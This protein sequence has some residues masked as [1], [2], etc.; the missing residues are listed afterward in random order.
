MKLF[1]FAPAV[2]RIYRPSLVWHLALVY[3]V[4]QLRPSIRVFSLAH[5]Y[6][7]KGAQFGEQW[8]SVKHPSTIRGA[9]K[10]AD[11][12]QLLECLPTSAPFE[13]GLYPEDS[14]I[15]DPA[16]PLMPYLDKLYIVDR[17]IPPKTIFHFLE[18]A[19]RGT[20]PTGKRT[21]LSIVSGEELELV[22]VPCNQWAL[23]PHNKITSPI[24]DMILGRIGSNED[25]M[26][27]TLVEKPVHA[28]KARLWEGIAP[29]SEHQWRQ[30][31]LNKAEN[32][33]YAC[34]YIEAVIHV[35]K[36]LNE[37][38]HISYMRGTSNHI[39]EHLTYFSEALN[40]MRR[41]DGKEPNVNLEGLWVE[42]IRA[43]YQVMTD[44]A[45]SWVISHVNALREPL[46]NEIIALGPQLDDSISPE[47][48]I[49]VEKLRKLAGIAAEADYTIYMSTDGY[50]GG[51]APP[52]EDSQNWQYP[53]LEKRRQAYVHSFSLIQQMMRLK[54][55]RAD[56]V[57][58]GT[59]T[60]DM[61]MENELL[62]AVE[63]QIQIQ[64][65]QRLLA[66]GEP[67]PGPRPPLP[68]ISD[69]TTRM[70]EIEGLGQP[71]VVK[72]GYAIYRLSYGRNPT[73][74]SEWAA[75]KA[76]IEKDLA[77]WGDG[78]N[79]VE[80]IKPFLK[81]TWFD[82]RELG[83]A[84][85]DIDGA[86]R[87]FNTFSESL[88]PSDGMDENTILIVDSASLASYSKPSTDDTDDTDDKHLLAVH[89]QYDPAEGIE[90]PEESP[91]YIGSMRILTRL[92]WSELFALTY[93]QAQWLEDLWPL[94]MGHP[95]K[96]Y[97]GQTVI[98]LQR[99]WATARM[100]GDS[101]L[102]ARYE[103]ER[104]K[105]DE[106]LEMWRR[107]RREKEL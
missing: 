28:M 42:F 107:E 33:D 15:M 8:K 103:A 6:H 55:E 101:E 57:V 70:R 72:V 65:R 106:K 18:F 79:G 86:K 104:K 100:A 71:P 26:R 92:V 37:P 75:L 44:S 19:D 24:S 63:S 21:N 29:L 50:K 36:Y 16:D 38:T 53:D 4:C 41:R 9:S 10:L 61:K 51:V 84:E 97:V 3:S 13:Q 81:V 54:D 22:V 45:H 62:K 25:W 7:S 88:T 76:A 58:P 105:R 80:D 14:E 89:A 39:A 17:L 96:V 77:S 87:H 30:K 43:K 27:L 49:V 90:R 98:E 1:T 56:K 102:K 83:L 68:W 35:F 46:L 74:E 82:G 40:N 94:A 99:R 91:G 59:A 20:L 23:P 48:L 66:R 11:V 95:E 93:N 69:V 31:G 73:D 5:T 67:E 47:Q 52:P 78:I 2:R 60:T 32:F 34:Q 64:H 12:Q 85:D